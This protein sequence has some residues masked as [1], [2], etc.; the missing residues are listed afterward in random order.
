MEFKLLVLL[1][2]RKGIV[3]SR[4]V[5]NNNIWDT[6]ADVTSRAIDTH[7][8]CLRYKLEDMGAFIETVRG[9]GYRYKDVYD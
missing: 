9:V 1:M 4:D 3:Q 2:Q 5:L 8:K 7:V 6:F